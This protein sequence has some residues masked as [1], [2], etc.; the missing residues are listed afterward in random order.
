MGRLGKLL[1][2][3]FLASFLVLIPGCVSADDTR[4]RPH[5]PY[6]AIATHFACDKLPVIREIA[7]LVDVQPVLA[8]KLSNAAAEAGHCKWFPPPES[9]FVILDSKVAQVTKKTAIWKGH[10]WSRYEVFI[11]EDTGRQ[12]NGAES[13]PLIPLEEPGLPL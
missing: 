9:L 8:L 1:T 10:T 4:E 11:L 6:K 3:T 13:R 2:G 5:V 7:K 12:L